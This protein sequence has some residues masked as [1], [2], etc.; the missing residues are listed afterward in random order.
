MR[1]WILIAFVLVSG[2]L[3][4]VLPQAEPS[5]DESAAPTLT[6]EPPLET[7]EEPG[8]TSA[9]VRTVSTNEA[10]GV[11]WRLLVAHRDGV[12]L[13]AWNASGEA[14]A[15]PAHELPL[16][17][18][19]GLGYRLV[20]GAEAVHG[21]TSIHE[22]N[23]TLAETAVWRAERIG[24]AIHHAGHYYVVANG[25]LNVLAPGL[26][27]LDSQAIP[28]W[29]APT[30][31]QYD[32]VQARDDVLLLGA[33]GRPAD[34]LV[35]G[36]A[37]PA[38][39]VLEQ[40]VRMPVAIGPDDARRDFHFAYL[41]IGD[42]HVWIWREATYLQDPTERPV[43]QQDHVS[44]DR[45]NWSFAG[46]NRSYDERPDGFVYGAHVGPV[47]ADG[48]QALLHAGGMFFLARLT[49]EGALL[50]A[51][52][53]IDVQ[54]S[55]LSADDVFYHAAADVTVVGSQTRATAWRTGP[56]PA[57]LAQIELPRAATDARLL[58]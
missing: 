35:Y 37:D 40:E 11:G 58:P 21:E 10:Q 4:R 7:C 30:R 42:G 54:L 25:T 16:A 9:G 29:Q 24:A 13:Y 45:Q 15:R 28:D 36:L 55:S 27:L 32:V 53:R 6:A 51:R 19:D 5:P 23:E 34:L 14:P 3:G 2:C 8:S 48:A 33:T 31:R 43:L 50:G 57:R 49:P 22:F 41:A 1:A 18:S 17:F 38:H 44:V 46:V 56:D 20:P 12:A 26:Q 39:P 47:E 52:C